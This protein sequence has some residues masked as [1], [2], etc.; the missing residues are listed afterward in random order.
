MATIATRLTSGG[1]ILIN[2]SLDEVSMSGGSAYFDGTGDYLTIGDNTALD[3]E[4]ENFTVEFWI[5]PIS[6]GGSIFSKRTNTSTFGGVILDHIGTA[7]LRLLATVSESNWEINTTTSNNTISLNSWN[8]IALARN[9]SNWLLFVNGNNVINTTLA[10]KVPNNAAAF[11]IGAGAAD[12]GAVLPASYL[13]NFRVVKGTALY[14]ANFI[15]SISILEPIPNTSLLLNFANSET[16]LRDRSTNNF[17]VTRFGDTTFSTLSPFNRGAYSVSSNILFTKNSDEVT[18]SS[19]S[20]FLDGSGDYMT[21]PSN[22]AFA[23]GTGNFTTEFWVYL[24]AQ[25]ASGSNFNLIDQRGGGNVE[26]PG[27]VYRNVSGVYYLTYVTISLASGTIID[28]AY[29]LPLTQWTHIALVRNGG[30][31]VLYVNGL[32]IGSNADSRNYSSTYTT[33]IGSFS[34]ASSFLNGYLSNLRIV[35]GSALYTANFIPSISILEPVAN[36]SLLL[37]FLDSRSFLTDRSTNNFTITSAGNTTFSTAAGNPF[38]SSNSAIKERKFAN[39]TLWAGIVDEFTGA[40][41]VDSSLV[42]WLDAGQAS[43]YSGSGTTW[44]DLSGLGNNETLI[45]GPTYSSSNGGIFTFNGSTQ[46]SIGPRPSSIV[47]N[48]GLSVVIWAKWTTTGTTVSTIQALVDN[49]HSGSPVQGFV[50]Q[51]RPDLS[52]SLTWGGAQSTF[53]VGDG[54]WRCCI[55]TNDGVTSKLYINGVLDASSTESYPATVQS[56]VNIGSWESGR[57]LGYGGRYLNGSVGLVMLYNRA[58]SADEVAQNFN[59]LRRRF[60]I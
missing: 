4:T 16:F 35:K 31:S 26:A 54:T 39:T 8:H 60:G 32:S 45:N 51:D 20:A 49:N 9:S 10:G 28:V 15:P 55:G 52:K 22:S 36:T 27:L 23:Y 29:T 21:V 53:Q 59:A 46:Y 18:L 50:M 1:N 48:G 3:F 37:N 33:Y 25:P 17:L 14:T 24:A 43:S 44:T 58:L 34:T 40:P 42:L 6:A 5:F 41:V 13:S 38:N 19:G 47:T 57:N 2:G 12:G 30:T 56:N 7:Q 11:T